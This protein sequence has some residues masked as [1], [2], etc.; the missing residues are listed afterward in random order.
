MRTLV[1]NHIKHARR[2]G[3]FFLCAFSCFLLFMPLGAY[4]GEL[5]PDKT[6]LQG[7]M[8][9][10]QYGCSYCHGIDG[11]TPAAKYVP[12]LRGKSHDRIVDGVSN[13]LRGDKNNQYATLMHDQYC[14]NEE[15]E[16]ESCASAPSD[17]ELRIIADWLA[18]APALAKK[19]QTPQQLYLTSKEAYEMARKDSSNLL[20]ID[21]RTR[22]EATY[23]GLPSLIDANIPLSRTGNFE[24]WDEKKNTFKLV[25]NTEF[26]RQINEALE[27]KGLNKDS[28]IVL[29]CR[30][31]SRSAKAAR[32]LHISG[33]KNVYSVTDGFEGDKMRTGPYKGQRLVNGWKNNDLPWSYKLDKAKLH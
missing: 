14:L 22:A 3:V 29:I 21:I 15:N 17:E 30:S 8:L 27:K 6:D 23:I 28:P 4:A 32:I 2:V 24:Q 16:G 26:I 33:F 18:A 7:K 25:R 19:K 13:I 9:Y 5:D 11:S 10:Q 31:G 1:A 20:F 12:V